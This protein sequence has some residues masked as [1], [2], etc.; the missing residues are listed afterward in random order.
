R[1]VLASVVEALRSTSGATAPARLLPSGDAY[2]LLKGDDRVLLVPQA[3]RREAL[4]TPRVWPGAVLV[5]GDI[6]GT[7]RRANEQMKIATW[8]RLAPAERAAVEEEALSLPLPGIAGALKVT[9]EG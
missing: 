7:W 8:R 4:W 6:V 1:M 9:W 2:T 5:G 3:A